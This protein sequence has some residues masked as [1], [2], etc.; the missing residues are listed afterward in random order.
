MFICSTNPMNDLVILLSEEGAGAWRGEEAAPSTPHT[1]CILG[2]VFT[3][4]AGTHVR[5]HQEKHSFLRVFPHILFLPSI[6]PVF[7][8]IVAVGDRRATFL[9][10]KKW[11]KRERDV[12]SASSY[13]P[14]AA[15][16]SES[17]KYSP[18]LFVFFSS[19]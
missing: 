9:P 19:F 13:Q 1:P 3:K 8:S 4:T 12:F 11:T 6:P 14:C 5:L 10:H 16:F 18:C 17:G 7:Y 2:I 15:H